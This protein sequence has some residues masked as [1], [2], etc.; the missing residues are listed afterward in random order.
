MT[1]YYYHQLSNDKSPLLER[2]QQVINERNQLRQIS[3]RPALPEVGGFQ[4]EAA[5][6]GPIIRYSPKFDDKQVHFIG[7]WIHEFDV[8]NRFKGEIGMFSVA[9]DF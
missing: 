9:L 8:Q 6:I 4:G 1:G 7:K 3:G 5:G 2:L